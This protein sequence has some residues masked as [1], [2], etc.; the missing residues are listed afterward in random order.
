MLKKIVSLAA[1]AAISLSTLQCAV[2][3][4]GSSPQEFI[5]YNFDKV[6]N[7]QYIA[8]AADSENYSLKVSM[9]NG[10]NKILIKNVNDVTYPQKKYITSWT[11]P[12]WLQNIMSFSADDNFKT[13]IEKGLSSEF[14]FNLR[15]ATADSGYKNAVIMTV[16]DNTDANAPLFRITYMANGDAAGNGMLSLDRK[17]TNGTGT[18]Y[19]SYKCFCQLDLNSWHNISVSLDETNGINAPVLYVDGNEMTF[20]SL[21]DTKVKDDGYSPVGL[22]NTVAVTYGRA[23]E[24]GTSS[25]YNSWIDYSKISMYD[26]ALS[27]S[28]MLETYEKEKGYYEPEFDVVL[29]DGLGNDVAQSDLNSIF[30]ADG[31]AP[32]IKIDTNG[33]ANTDASLFNNENVIISD[34]T[35]NKQLNATGNLTDGIYTLTSDEF[36][37]G[38]EYELIIS[39]AVTESRTVNQTLEFATTADVPVKAA[40]FEMKEA[41][42]KDSISGNVTTMGDKTILPIN[43]YEDTYYVPVLDWAPSIEPS[44]QLRAALNGKFTLD[45]WFKKDTASKKNEQKIWSYAENSESGLKMMLSFNGGSMVFTERYSYTENDEENTDLRAYKTTGNISLNTGWNHI[46]FAFDPTTDSKTAML[47]GKTLTFGKNP[48]HWGSMAD[49]SLPEGAKPYTSSETAGVYLNGTYQKIAYSY[50][51]FVSPYQIGAQSYYSG[52]AT[53]AYMSYLSSKNTQRYCDYYD[54]TVMQ[55]GEEV[56]K[57]GLKALDKSDITVKLANVADGSADGK[58]YME[59]AGGEKL[60]PS[61]TYDSSTASAVFNGMKAGAYKLVVEGGITD[62]SSAVIRDTDYTL[63]LTVTGKTEINLLADGEVIAENTDVSGKTVF[64][65]AELV[66][67][68]KALLIIA[69][70]KDGKFVGLD[71]SDEIIET[72]DGN[73]ISVTAEVGE[74]EQVK[75]MLWDGFE[76]INPVTESKNY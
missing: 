51:G 57:D 49:S 20:K 33:V 7:I 76:F 26:G 73:I 46:I 41:D 60:I 21:S 74:S 25:W 37:A 43:K 34:V 22:N 23:R 32:S 55:N 17:I 24:I 4:E 68:D 31:A 75:L 59:N 30:A 47:N 72:A 38:H 14:W 53:A 2:M 15:N 61:I 3:A 69:R 1:A 64:G 35:D 62:T 8:N 12:E 5:R 63:P 39:S 10:L 65:K 58:V 50:G 52:T 48:L 54:L 29:Q 16:E 6:E 18:I 11:A 28:Q 71:K 42:F 66:G 36:T 56:D 67:I 40:D 9:Q 70:Y 27:E 45:L 13:K 44:E 19:N